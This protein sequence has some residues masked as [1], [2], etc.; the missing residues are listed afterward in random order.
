MGLRHRHN[1]RRA[2]SRGLQH[3]LASGLGSWRP[4]RRDKAVHAYVSEAFQTICLPLP[5]SRAYH[6][7]SQP[8]KK[9]TIQTLSAQA[10]GNFWLWRGKQR[11]PHLE[12]AVCSL[13]LK[14]R[15]PYFP[16]IPSTGSRDLLARSL[17]V[18]MLTEVISLHPE[19]GFLRASAG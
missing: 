3:E 4:F 6:T 11:C 1:Y 12:N 16:A 2:Q 10:S 13:I 18:D 17:V 9:H 14:G 7:V 15:A 8:R 5:H 19:F